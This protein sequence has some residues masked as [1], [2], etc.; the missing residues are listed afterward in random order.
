MGI[1]YIRR[2]EGTD[3]G[4]AVWQCLSCKQTAEVRSIVRTTWEGVPN[5]KFCPF[6]G[7]EWVGEKVCEDTRK[8]ELGYGLHESAY[9]ARTKRL[10]PLEFELEHRF[11]AKL[12]SE[13]ADEEDLSEFERVAGS[14][15]SNALIAF[16]SLKEARLH[17][18]AD[19]QYF[20]TYV[21]RVVPVLGKKGK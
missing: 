13:D 8:W 20:G 16:Q 18:E 14:K 10:C 11:I 6:C 3:D 21:F 1:P 4:C 15:V 7:V 9:L 2:V 5:W 12:T 19:E 17:Q